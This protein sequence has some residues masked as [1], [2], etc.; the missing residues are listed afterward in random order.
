MGVQVPPLTKGKK[1]RIVIQLTGQLSPAY[2]KGLKKELD[3][4]LDKYR[5]KCGKL[6]PPPPKRK[7]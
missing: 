2:A 5:D 6:T 3:R 7:S 1:H 4:V